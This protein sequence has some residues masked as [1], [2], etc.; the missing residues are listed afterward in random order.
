MTDFTNLPADITPAQFFKAIEDALASEPA[1]AGASPEKLVLHVTGDQ[2]GTWSMGF[3]G[4]KLA[5]EQLAT[6]GAPLQISMTT[7]DLRAFVAGDVRDAVKAKTGNRGAIDP[8]QMAKAFKITSKTDQVKAFSGDLQVR[9]EDKAKG[10]TYKLTLTFGGGVPNVG[11]PTTTISMDLADFLSVLGGELNPQ[12]A[13]FTGKLRL[14]GDMNLAMGLMAL[15][16]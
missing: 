12:T 3:V 10:K 5:I 6:T 4:G 16:M 14:D 13:F 15:A 8:K 1:P 7:D 2:G 9:I 11:A